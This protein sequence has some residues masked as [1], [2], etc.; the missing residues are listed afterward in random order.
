M[1]QSLCQRLSSFKF[2]CNKA[3][4]IILFSTLSFSY[5]KTFVKIETS[6]QLVTIVAVN[7]LMNASCDTKRKHVLIVIHNFQAGRCKFGKFWNIRAERYI[8]VA[9][10]TRV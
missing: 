8:P 2:N 5:S 10:S 3:T 6:S 9:G 4:T 1:K 7:A